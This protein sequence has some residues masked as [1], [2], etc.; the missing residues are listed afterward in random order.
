MNPEDEQ[1]NPKGTGTVRSIEFFQWM[2]DEC[3]MGVNM[4]SCCGIGR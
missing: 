1:V 3:R 2:F 4:G